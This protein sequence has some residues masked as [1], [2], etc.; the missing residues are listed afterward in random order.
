[1]FQEFLTLGPPLSLTCEMC[2]WP[3]VFKCF[4]QNAF[5]SLDPMQPMETPF[6]PLVNS[7]S[8][9]AFAPVNIYFGDISKEAS[10]FSE[11]SV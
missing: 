10:A 2:K 1:M 9:N 5:A 8:Q 6:W 11:A 7:F 3:G 4:S